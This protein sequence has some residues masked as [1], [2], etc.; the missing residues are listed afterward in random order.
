VYVGELRL[1]HG[2]TLGLLARD[3]TTSAL[4]ASTQMQTDDV[5]LV[6]TEPEQRG[7]AE[8]RIRAVHRSGRL[9]TWEGDTGS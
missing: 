4:R 5:L 3:G 1:P 8:R 7:A 2:S 6:F 9:A